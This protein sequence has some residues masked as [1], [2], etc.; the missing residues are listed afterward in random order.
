MTQPTPQDGSGPAPHP[1]QGSSQPQPQPAPAQ[2]H[3]S[4]PEQPQSM[5]PS[6]VLCPYCG[7]LS[8]DNKRCAH[9]H[10]YFDILSRQRSQN[11]MGP[12]FIR[13]VSKPFV[14]GCSYATL[15]KMT[16]RGKIKP[17]TVIRGPSTRQFWTFARNAPGIA[18]LFGE[19]HACHEPVMPIA[20]LCPNCK[21][22]F[23][24]DE[25]RQYMG[26]SPVHLLPGDADAATIAA[27]LGGQ[28]SAGAAIPTSPPPSTSAVAQQSS[29]S[30]RPESPTAP[31]P[32]SDADGR[33]AGGGAPAF[34]PPL[35]TRVIVESVD[36]DPDEDDRAIGRGFPVGVLVTLVIFGVLMI[37]GGIW[38]WGYLNE[39]AGTSSAK[40]DA[41]SAVA[42]EIAQDPAPSPAE[43]GFSADASETAEPAGEGEEGETVAS[44]GTSPDIGEVDPDEAR[45]DA[46]T[47]DTAVS[48]EPE[49]LE[50]AYQRVLRLLAQ[51][52]PDEG[53]LESALSE[54]N[55]ARRP[56]VE[57]LRDRRAAQR[58]LGRTGQ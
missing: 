40:S 23:V 33:T 34:T 37:G 35:E 47:G 12:W 48:E 3:S 58:Q 8:T 7:S 56:E 13:D 45:R 27:S 5:G 26:L 36:E 50:A 10:G 29:G 14:P 53:E 9:C 2:Q 55:P 51:P 1:G 4:R 42:P 25:D 20:K 49:P 54:L 6:M 39:R 17:E 30:V 44:V 43:P 15:V 52:N 19:C 21:A 11:A 24:V 38:A 41:S 16:E 22:S 28:A 18:H 57:A 46:E 32:A 31:A